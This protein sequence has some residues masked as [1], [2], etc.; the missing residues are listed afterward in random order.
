MQNNYEMERR[1]LWKRKRKE[2]SARVSE[3]DIL[4]HMKSVE[5]KASMLN[6]KTAK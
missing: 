3:K 4:Q 1:K 2:S 5:E 6:F